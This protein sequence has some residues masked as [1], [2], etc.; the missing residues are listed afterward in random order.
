VG[1]PWRLQE[2]P[3]THLK[4]RFSDSPSFGR[5]YAI[6][7]NQVRLGALEISPG[8]RDSTQHPTVRT[9]VELEWVRLLAYDTISGFLDHIASQV[10]NPDPSTREYFQARAGIHSALTS[11]LWNA[12]IIHQFN[13]DEE[14][15][16]FG[17]LTLQFNGSAIWYMQRVAE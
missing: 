4:L 2:L 12:Q 14:N 15:F 3:D 9:E 7:Y 16:D 6:F 10:C 17:E 11:A 5:S 13:T 8:F 1:G